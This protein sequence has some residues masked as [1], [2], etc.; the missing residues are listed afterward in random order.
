VSSAN[1]SAPVATWTS[2]TSGVLG[3]DGTFSFTDNGAAAAQARFYRLST[4][5][6]PSKKVNERKKSRGAVLIFSAGLFSSR[7]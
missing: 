1:V 4:V 3:A 7:T 5:T 6:R 2:L